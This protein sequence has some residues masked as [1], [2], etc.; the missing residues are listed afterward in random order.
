MKLIRFPK[1]KP[2]RRETTSSVDARMAVGSVTFTCTTCTSTTNVD[3]HGMIFRYLSF[4]CTRC[5]SPHRMTNPAFAA[6]NP[7]KR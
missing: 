6:S 4:Y 1:G 3:F 2:D 5:G 7:P